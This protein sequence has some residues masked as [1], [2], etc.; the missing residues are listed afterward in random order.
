M[1]TYIADE[2]SINPEILV[3]KSINRGMR[4]TVQTVLEFLY[5]GTSKEEILKQ[6]LM[7]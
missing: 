3:V 1:A 7:L 5:A 4:I 6:Y 2:I